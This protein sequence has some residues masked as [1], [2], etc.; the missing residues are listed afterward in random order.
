[1]YVHAGRIIKVEKVDLSDP[2]NSWYRVRVIAFS[3]IGKQD[4]ITGWIDGKWFKKHGVAE[5]P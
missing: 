3:T 5:Q 2:D 1:M 4:D